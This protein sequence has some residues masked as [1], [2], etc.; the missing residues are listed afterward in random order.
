MLPDYNISFKIS[1][2]SNRI[3]LNLIAS[4]EHFNQNKTKYL[5]ISALVKPVAAAAAFVVVVATVAVVRNLH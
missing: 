5:F 3:C 1:I 2:P 4:E